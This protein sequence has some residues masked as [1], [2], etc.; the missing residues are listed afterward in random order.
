L[1]VASAREAWAARK[2]TSR[3]SVCRATI[4]FISV[5][6]FVIVLCEMDKHIPPSGAWSKFPVGPRRPDHSTRAIP[7][8][9]AAVIQANLHQPQFRS[10]P[11]TGVRPKLHTRRVVREDEDVAPLNAGLSEFRQTGIYELPADAATPVTFQHRQ[12]MQ[13]TA[14]AV[15]TAQHGAD[16][17]AILFRNKAEARV[18]PQK[19]RYGRARVGFVQPHALGALPK[20]DDCIVIFD[21]ERADD[22]SI[23]VGA[24]GKFPFHSTVTLLARLRGLSTSQPRATAM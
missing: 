18:A 2:K 10:Q 1:C 20:G 14:P 11:P 4:F 15:V 19:R 13:V 23:A 16:D 22:C 7:S 21:A 6:L 3:L 5:R 9:A 12:M 17:S 8:R 24:L